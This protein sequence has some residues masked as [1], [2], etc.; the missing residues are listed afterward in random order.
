MMTEAMDQ[1]R[2]PRERT[3]DKIGTPTSGGYAEEQPALSKI[4]RRNYKVQC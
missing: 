3:S 1:I 2:F 4:G